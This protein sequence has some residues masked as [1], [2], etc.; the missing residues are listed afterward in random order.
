MN[1]E[2]PNLQSAM[3]GLTQKICNILIESKKENNAKF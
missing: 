2:R 3:E 1:S